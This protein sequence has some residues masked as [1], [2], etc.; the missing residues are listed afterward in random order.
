MVTQYG[1]TQKIGAIKLGVSEGEPFLGKNYGHQRDYSESVA[2]TVDQEIHDLIQNAHQEAFDILEKN[3]DILDQ[4]VVILLEKETILKDEIEKIFKKV[5]KVSKRPAW[6][7]SST[8]K[9][10]TQPPVAMSPAKPASPVTSKDDSENTV[11]KPR[12][13][14][15]PP[16]E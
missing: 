6:T 15:A 14:A 9:P 12:K 4:L 10:S 7:G 3:R 13:K 1:M 5:R 2:A 11:R 8:R 16:S